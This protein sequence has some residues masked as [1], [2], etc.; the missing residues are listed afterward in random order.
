MRYFRRKT[1]AIAMFASFLL[2]GPVSA[3]TESEARDFFEKFVAAQNAHDDDAVKAMLWNSSRT[4]W[5]T[6]GVEIRGPESIA[7]RLKTYYEGTWHLEADMT[8]FRVTVISDDFMQILVP[9]LFTH[10]LPGQPPQN[11]K[12]LISQTLI[13]EADGWRVAAIMPVADTQFK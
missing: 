3:A 2:A 8:Q 10:G 12:F 7:N 11:S 13:H 6:R 9:I 4:L 5:F 1:A